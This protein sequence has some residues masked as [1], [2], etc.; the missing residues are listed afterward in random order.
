MDFA[1]SQQFDR[2]GKHRVGSFD[3]LVI[4]LVLPGVNQRVRVRV[5][6]GLFASGLGNDVKRRNT[7][8]DNLRGVVLVDAG[9][10]LVGLAGD[11]I[12]LVAVEDAFDLQPRVH[13]VSRSEQDDGDD[14]L[15]AML[16]QQFFEFVSVHWIR[17]SEKRCEIQREFRRVGGRQGCSMY[18]K[19]LATS[20]TGSREPR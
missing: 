7:G 1:K 12:G 16:H 19:V 15:L 13:H 20:A 9:A 2:W 11:R 3:D 10:Y 5:D 8:L 4:L 18:P 6:A 14:D 17:P